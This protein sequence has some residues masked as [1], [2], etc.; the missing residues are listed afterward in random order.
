MDIT[1]NDWLSLKLWFEIAQPQVHGYGMTCVAMTTPLQ[2]MSGA[3]EEVRN[4]SMLCYTQF[5]GQEILFT[6][7]S[8]DG[9]FDMVL[10]IIGTCPME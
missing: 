3:D 8:L 6:G 7:T 2:Y 10:N 4:C 1:T 5:Y 9:Y